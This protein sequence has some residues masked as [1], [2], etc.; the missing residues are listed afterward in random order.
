MK[1]KKSDYNFVNSG[2]RVGCK[3]AMGKHR[4]PSVLRADGV[5]I[6]ATLSI[7]QSWKG[8]RTG[9][10][11]INGFNVDCERQARV[12]EDHGNDSSAVERFEEEELVFDFRILCLIYL[13]D[14]SCY[15]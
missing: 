12:D 15:K 9:R 5:H 2:W 6:K 7:G 1:K 11:Y 8:C 13:L 10:I 3:G 4:L 14:I